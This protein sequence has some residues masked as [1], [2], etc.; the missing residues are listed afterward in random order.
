MDPTECLAQIFEDLFEGETE[1]AVNG[2]SNL[3]KWLK[4]GGFQPHV[5]KA[6]Q[7]FYDRNEPTITRLIEGE[8]E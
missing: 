8:Y 5:A 6:M 7:T 1:A 2:M 4:D 3:D